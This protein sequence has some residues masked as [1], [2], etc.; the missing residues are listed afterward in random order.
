L[1]LGELPA[2]LRS[3]LVHQYDV[4]PYDADV[5]VNQGRPFAEYYLAV[6]QACG[7]GKQASNWVTQDV[8]RWLKDHDVAIDQFPVPSSELGQLIRSVHQGELP[9]SRGKEVFGVMIQTAGGLEQ[10]LQ[11][12]GIESVDSGELVDLGREL[13]EANPKIVADV[14]SGKQQAIGALVGQAKK[15]NAN[16]DPGGIRQILLDLIGQLPR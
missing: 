9:R 13:L 1:A 11:Q 3:R 7:D 14:Q 6:A 8:L 5:I 16:I 12:L 2:R 15:R 10:T 4:T